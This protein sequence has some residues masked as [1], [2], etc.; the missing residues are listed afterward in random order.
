[1]AVLHSDT[2]RIGIAFELHSP[3]LEHT[4]AGLVHCA[5]EAG[6]WSFVRA[7]Q[8]GHLRSDPREFVDL[9]V[10]RHM[11]TVDGY[12]HA[13]VPVVQVGWSFDSPSAAPR[14]ASDV[15][16]CGVMMAEHFAER[17]LKRLACVIHKQRWHTRQRIMGFCRAAKRLGCEVW[18]GRIH[19]DADMFLSD[20][21]SHAIA[22]G[23]LGDPIGLMTADTELAWDVKT[24]LDRAGV[25][26]PDQVA[27]AS[28]GEDATLFES[29]N[30]GITSI[31]QDTY[32]IGLQAGA[33][34]N[35]LM[36][37]DPS[38]PKTTLVPPLGVL[39]R[40]STDL[41]AFDDRD[42][43]NCLKHIWAEV[44]DHISV[45]DLCERVMLSPSTLTRRFR[46][47]LGRTP[48]QEIKRSRIQTALRLLSTTQKP[49]IDVAL[50][51]GLTSQ[52][53]LNRY[54]SEET[55]LTPKQF[56]EKH[57]RI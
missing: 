40:G 10:T 5:R 41:Y 12:R 32:G 35:R 1:M 34:I 42:V 25:A 20:L 52:S 33:I 50:S 17:G 30:P 22:Q 19:R 51:S 37:G 14:I 8:S 45:D 16:L 57:S 44:A 43:V 36:R 46:A 24:A 23:H 4:F 13:G 26:M 7:P 47:T 49:L 54:V 39:E 6:N 9:I 31:A 2:L 29:M 38:V 27:L 15:R 21:M 53:L 28:G 55:G 3:W 18:L 56:R 48:M 11:G